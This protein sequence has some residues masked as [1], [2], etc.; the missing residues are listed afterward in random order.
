MM[1]A[2][3]ILRTIHEAAPDYQL[4]M[5]IGTFTLVDKFG[6]ESDPP[7]MWLEISK[8]TM[9]KINWAD[10]DF[11]GTLFYKRIPDI[12]DKLKYHP[13]MLKD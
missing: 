4:I 1:D 13:V 12:A 7:V 2:A 8:E 6:N 11:T 5:L 9:E 3:N 10:E